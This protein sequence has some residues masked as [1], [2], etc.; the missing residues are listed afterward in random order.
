MAYSRFPVRTKV[1]TVVGRQHFG[2][3]LREPHCP[4]PQLHDASTMQTSDKRTA[5]SLRSLY[6]TLIEKTSQLPKSQYGFVVW[7][8]LHAWGSIWVPEREFREMYSKC[9]LIWIVPIMLAHYGF[10]H[11]LLGGVSENL[12]WVAKYEFMN[13]YIAFSMKFQTCSLRLEC[14]CV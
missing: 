12:I 8:V 14:V 9:K 2:K 6:Q 1:P 3:H 10:L 4:S 5:S 13:V 11:M 7:F